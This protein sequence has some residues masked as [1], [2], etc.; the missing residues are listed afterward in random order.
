[1]L[2]ET[3]RVVA[4]E[5]PGFG[6]SAENQRSQ[7]FAEIGATLVRAAHQLGLERFNLWGTS[8]G[9]AVAVWAALG[10]PE[11]IDALVLEAPG[12]ILPEARIRPSRSPEEMRQRLYAH[13]ERQ[14][15]MATPDPAIAAKQFALMRRLSAVPREEVERRL[16][17]LAVPSLVVF[18]TRDQVISS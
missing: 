17:E 2:A 13:P 1:L 9:G 5:V 16:A 18:G 11:S 14:T 4:F 7:S 10:A 3:F 8:F 12:A 6:A 15:P